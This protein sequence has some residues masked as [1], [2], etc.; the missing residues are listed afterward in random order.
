MS[1]HIVSLQEY[2]L[3]YVQ[4]EFTFSPLHFLSTIKTTLARR[5]LTL[6]HSKFSV[7]VS[8]N[9]EDVMESLFALQ[10]PEERDQRSEDKCLRK[11]T[12][13]VEFHQSLAATGVSSC[14]HISCVTSDRV[15]VSDNVN[16]LILIDKTGVPLHRVEDLCTYVSRGLHTVSTKNELIYIDRN[17]TI[18][19]LSKD[20]KTTTT[21]KENTDHTWAPL[22]VYS[23]PSTGDLLVGMHRKY[24][25]PG[26]VMRYNRSGHRTQTIQHDTTGQELYNQPNYITENN[27]GDV[28]VSDY[29][30]GAVYFSNI[31]R[32]SLCGYGTVVVTERGGRHRFSYTGHPSG[33]ELQPF[34]ICTNELSNILVCDDISRTVHIIEKDDLNQDTA[35]MESLSEIQ[36]T[37]TER[38]DMMS[39][40]NYFTLSH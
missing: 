40:P 19:K 35:V 2:E 10:I 26:K 17:D 27:N 9:K 14:R 7:T 33:S 31:Y 34:G 21:F 24:S 29:R 5:Y 28:V 25:G 12:S 6:R 13:D 11:L 3:R 4:P 38:P 20:T 23:S 30:T 36:S 1:I 15:W 16:N 39:S 32:L 18:K 8:F 22:F 37:E